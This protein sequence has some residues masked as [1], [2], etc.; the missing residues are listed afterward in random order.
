MNQTHGIEQALS[1][2]TQI[3]TA[4]ILWTLVALSL[5]G[6]AVILE[7]AAYFFSSRDDIETLGNDLRQL[8]GEADFTR[9][10][11][12]LSESPS[13]EA[14]VALAAL[15][16][17]DPASADE[18][19]LGAAESVRLDMERHLAFLSTVGSNAP[20]VGLLGTVVGIVSAFRE[21]NTSG[22][23]LTDG[24]MA[25]IG[26]ALVATAVGLVVALPA[27]AA[28]NVFRRIVATRMARAE[29]LR[30]LVL[31]ELKQLARES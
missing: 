16:S 22:G 25:H 17:R 10:K 12:R 11:R 5:L 20:F 13:G 30:H 6:L 23:A 7:R 21:L 29:S 3:G 24:L 14:K 15:R 28:F 1:G 9:A 26:E 19:M 18:H 31:A 2:M 27:V 8:L 4:W